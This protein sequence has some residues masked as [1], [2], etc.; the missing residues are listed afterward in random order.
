MK[1]SD[2]IKLNKKE[3]KKIEQNKKEIKMYLIYFT[4]T[5]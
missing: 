5:I 1:V 2:F 4:S 3:N